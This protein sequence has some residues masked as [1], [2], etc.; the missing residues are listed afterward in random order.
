MDD[1]KEASIALASNYAIF[2]RYNDCV[3]ENLV[4]K[5]ARFS[6]EEILTQLEEIRRLKT[7][8]ELFRSAAETVRR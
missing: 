3:A 4:S 5:L 7:Q 6:P 8:A 2:A 1:I